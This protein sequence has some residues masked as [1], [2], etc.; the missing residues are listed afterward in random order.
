L[1]RP[2]EYRAPVTGISMGVSVADH[3]ELVGQICQ[4]AEMPFALPLFR[5]TGWKF[6]VQRWRASV[7]CSLTELSPQFCGE[8]RWDQSSSGGVD[9]MPSGNQINERRDDF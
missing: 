5:H 4:A 2:R 9:P 8:T 1:I 6:A 7:A 3:L